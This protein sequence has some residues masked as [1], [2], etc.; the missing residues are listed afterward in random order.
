MGAILAKA[1]RK[2]AIRQRL[3]DRLR[4]VPCFS[5]NPLRVPESA[6]AFENLTGNEWR[7]I[8]SVC[9]ACLYLTR[10]RP[11]CL[12]DGFRFFAGHGRHFDWAIRQGKTQ[13]NQHPDGHGLQQCMY[14][15]CDV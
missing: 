7:S 10:S 15:C 5:S 1:E 6:D 13:Q 8:A 12:F 11:G 3:G 14:C 9:I 4:T 2:A